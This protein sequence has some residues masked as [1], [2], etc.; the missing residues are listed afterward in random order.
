MLLSLV[1]SEKTRKLNFS[2]HMAYWITRR[3]YELD[4]FSHALSLIL[5]I[6]SVALISI[7]IDKIRI[8][9]SNFIY[10]QLVKLLPEKM[11]DKL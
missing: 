1:W 9:I 6:F 5:L 3:L 10:K 4:C 7:F 2:P 11:T 8:V